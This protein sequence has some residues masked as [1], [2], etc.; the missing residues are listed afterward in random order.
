MAKLVIIKFTLLIILSILLTNKGIN[1]NPTD[2][3]KITLFLNGGINLSTISTQAP[4]KN[5]STSGGYPFIGISVSVRSSKYFFI[6]TGLQ[7][8][9]SE[10]KISQPYRKQRNTCLDAHLIPQVRILK[11]IKVGAGFIYSQVLS[12]KTV[13]PDGSNLFG[14]KKSNAEGFGSFASLTGGVNIELYK[15]AEIGFTYSHNVTNSH[16]NYGNLQVSVN[17]H[18]NKKTQKKTSPKA[19]ARAQIL[20]LKNGTLL[21]RLKTSTP[22][23][24]ALK[25]SGKNELAEKTQKRQE[26][27]NRA[28]ITAFSE[29]FNFCKVGFFYSDN[30]LKVKNRIFDGILLNDSL[31][32]DTAIYIHPEE[33]FFIAEFGNTE[34][35]TTQNFSHY[36]KATSQEGR[37]REPVYY[38]GTNFGIN[39][40]II[41]DEN[42]DQLQNPFPY[43]IR[44]Q[45]RSLKKHPEQWIFLF[46]VALIS[47]AWNYDDAVEK[48]DKKLEK[49]YNRNHE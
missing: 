23:I 31:Q 34:Q 3:Q 42:F 4:F 30:S 5:Y 2:E 37:G 18:I 32:P 38:G 15:R 39:A 49:F 14:F 44:T 10:I 17:W 43:Y 8:G 27:E 45:F 22:K 7:Y 20:D 25:K 29:R 1:Q 13:T 36:S 28:I 19:I 16:I 35:D 21:V 9:Y 33:S 6:K 40:L 41:R 48:M 11:F 47:G 26:K 24:E 12:S 46:P